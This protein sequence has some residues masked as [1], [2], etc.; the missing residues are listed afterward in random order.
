MTGTDDGDG[1]ITTARAGHL[2][3]IRIDRPKKLNGFTPKMQAELAEAYTLLETDDELWVG[4]LLAEGPHFTAGLDLP[5][6]APRMRKG[7][8]T[9][10]PGLID[11][12]DL[13]EPRRTKPVVVAVKGI[14]YTIGIEL[15]L[16]ADITI[17]SSDC[18]F[19]QLEVKRG[20]IAAGGATVRM[21]ERAGWGDAMLRLLTDDEFDAAA[22]LH[23]HF[24]QEVVA[25]DR[26]EA[27][28]RE[29]AETICRQAPL[30]VRA[31]IA[32]ARKGLEVGIPA[33]TAEFRAIN[34]RLSA[35]EDAAEGVRSFVEK[36]PP[37][38]KGR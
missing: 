18:R 16:A 4:L 28:A 34:Q 15:M 31:T 12:L 10:P 30:A 17:A 20:I 37:V 29:V 22:A 21:V 27:R 24:V 5:K 33:A 23:M 14:T 2:L 6:N 35:T 19:A 36:R 38:F 26:V 13:R 32:N 3:E 1:R 7:E 11:P 25:P 8:P 9:F